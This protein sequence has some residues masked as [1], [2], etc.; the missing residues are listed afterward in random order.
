M[1][2]RGRGPAARGSTTRRSRRRCSAS[3]SV[4]VGSPADDTAGARVVARLQGVPQ[5]AW[6]LRPLW[7]GAGSSRAAPGPGRDRARRA[8]PQQTRPTIP[9]PLR[10]QAPLR[11]LSPAAEQP[12]T[13]GGLAADRSRPRPDVGGRDR[14]CRASPPAVDDPSTVPLLDRT[15]ALRLEGLDE[16]RRRRSPVRR[17]CPQTHWRSRR[18]NC[19]RSHCG[20]MSEEDRR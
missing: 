9:R 7:P 17:R 18:W 20:R 15:G 8:D 12:V 10:H 4:I 6:H 16:D 19:P 14:G 11:G 3:S 13:A 5:R 1:S 2:R